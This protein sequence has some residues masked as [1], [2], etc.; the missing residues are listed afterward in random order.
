MAALPCI[1]L[2]IRFCLHLRVCADLFRVRNLPIGAASR[3]TTSTITQTM[4]TPNGATQDVLVP[5]ADPADC[6]LRSSP[7]A[8][9]PPPSRSAAAQRAT[10]TSTHVSCRN[11]PQA[12]G[13]ENTCRLTSSAQVRIRQRQAALLEPRTHHRQSVLHKHTADKS[14]TQHSERRKESNTPAS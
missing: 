9:A 14:T 4:S 11:Q 10:G 2:C 7:P 12:G 1:L 8:L 3:R 13:A 6:P 5:E